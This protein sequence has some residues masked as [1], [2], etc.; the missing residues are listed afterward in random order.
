[1]VKK[2]KSCLGKCHVQTARPE[3]WAL[4]F[5][6]QVDEPERVNAWFK[7]QI[8]IVDD[9]QKQQVAKMQESVQVIS[10]DSEPS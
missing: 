6:F 5:E 4:D 10:P 3:P 2:F 1:V 7:Q 9:A 8:K